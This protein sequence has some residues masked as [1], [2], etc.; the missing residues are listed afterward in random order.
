M[1]DWGCG[2]GPARSGARIYS[3]TNVAN[4]LNSL[5]TSNRKAIVDQIGNNVRIGQCT[6]ITDLIGLA[7]L[8][9]GSRHLIKLFIKR[10]VRRRLS[11]RR[12]EHAQFEVY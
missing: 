10:E 4:R 9:P 1:N 6:R 3:R 2:Q 11:S 7:A 8:V 5:T 12:S